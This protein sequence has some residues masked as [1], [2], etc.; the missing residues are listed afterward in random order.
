M[1]SVLESVAGTVEDH[2]TVGSGR[3][4]VVASPRT[5]T[6]IRSSRPVLVPNCLRSPQSRTKLFGE[7]ALSISIKR[8]DSCDLFPDGPDR[9]DAVRGERAVNRI[10]G[11]LGDQMPC[12]VPHEIKNH[13][14]VGGRSRL[15]D[16]HRRQSHTSQWCLRNTAAT[17][18]DRSP[19]R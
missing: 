9:G 4:V 1:T 5:L 6:G 10:A 15:V 17:F 19:T 11:V 7:L 14:H 18:P 12:S 3:D 8:V 2:C 13:D 16:R